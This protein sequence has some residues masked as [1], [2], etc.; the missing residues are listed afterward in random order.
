MSATV[1]KIVTFSRWVLCRC[2][3]IIFLGGG[4]GNALSQEA[5]LFL[6][7]KDVRIALEQ[8]NMI[9]NAISVLF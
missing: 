1:V 4:G 2:A 7:F 6:G 5:V 3:F 9:F 8:P